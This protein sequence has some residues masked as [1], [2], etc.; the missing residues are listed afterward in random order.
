VLA[1]GS[2]VRVKVPPLWKGRSPFEVK[3]A[4]EEQHEGEGMQWMNGK[5][6]VR[7]EE[8]FL[9]TFKTRPPSLQHAGRQTLLTADAAPGRIAGVHP[10]QCT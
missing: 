4:Q 2:K 3:G 8:Q 9:G 1:G 7:A 6:W 10:C 5:S